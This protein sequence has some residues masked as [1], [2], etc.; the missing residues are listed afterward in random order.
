MVVDHRDAS[1]LNDLLETLA[2][3]FVA[4][5]IYGMPTMMLLFLLLHP[6]HQDL[7]GRAA[8]GVAFAPVQVVD[9]ATG[10]ASQPATGFDEDDLGPLFLRSQGCHDAA[11][12]AAIHTDVHLMMRDLCRQ[13]VLAEQ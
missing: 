13:A 4:D 1:V 6:L 11:C 3:L 9:P 5:A 7:V 12:R 10:H 8:H 2:I